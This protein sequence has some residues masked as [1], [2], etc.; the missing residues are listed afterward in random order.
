MTYIFFP[1]PHSSLLIFPNLNLESV[2][3]FSALAEQDILFGLSSP[4]SHQLD[5]IYH[6]FIK[7]CLLSTERSLSPF[8]SLENK[9]ANK[10]HQSIKAHGSF[11]QMKGIWKIL[12]R[13]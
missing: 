12:Y 10:N 13:L 9:I 2:S 11:H 3:S 4:L 8:L 6:S 5:N 1:F 7:K